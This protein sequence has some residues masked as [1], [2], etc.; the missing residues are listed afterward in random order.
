MDGRG[1]S[2][3]ELREMLEKA[4]SYQEGVAGR[5]LIGA[6]LRGT[7]WVVVVEPDEEQQLLVAV[8]A[9]PVD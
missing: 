1:F 9:Y 2:E 3:V 8:T 4:K 5:W 6:R 7:A